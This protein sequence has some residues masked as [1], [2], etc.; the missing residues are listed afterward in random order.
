MAI[1]LC[2]GKL[3]VSGVGQFDAQ[4]GFG[5]MIGGTFSGTTEYFPESGSWRTLTLDVQE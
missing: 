3:R 5:A 1:Q 4:N 2:D